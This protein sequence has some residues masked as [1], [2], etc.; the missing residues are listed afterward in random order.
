MSCFVIS[1]STSLLLEP[2][3]ETVHSFGTDAEMKYFELAGDE[4]H[5]DW[6]FFRRF[7]MLLFD[8]KVNTLLE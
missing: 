6:Y 7:K 3:G 4:M 8:K 2:D 5:R 1:A